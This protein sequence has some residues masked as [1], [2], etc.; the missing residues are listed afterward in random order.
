[1]R[2]ALDLSIHFPY[3]AL[4][5]LTHRDN[6]MNLATIQQHAAAHIANNVSPEATA[7]A[8]AATVHAMLQ[9]TQGTTFANITQA[10]RVKTAAAHKDSVI[11][12]VSIANVTLASNL[13]EFTNIYKNKVQREIGKDFEVSATWFKHTKCYSIVEHNTKGTMYLYAMYNNT[14]AVAYYNVDTNSVMTKEEVAEYLTPSA[15]K[16][17]LEPSAPTYNKTNDV[18]HNVTIRTIGLANIV[19]MNANRQSF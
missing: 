3:N 4:H 17:L 5:T 2:K 8:N 10:T 12:K 16:K 18:E 1:M 19:H 15:A 11:V 6:K 7:A 9:H 13:N 14:T